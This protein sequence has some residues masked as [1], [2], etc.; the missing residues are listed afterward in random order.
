MRMPL[1]AIYKDDGLPTRK[2]DV[3]GSRQ[4][5]PVKAEPETHCMQR[6]AHG[7]LWLRVAASNSGHV[8]AASVRDVGEVRLRLALA[9]FGWHCPTMDSRDEAVRQDD[10]RSDRRWVLVTDDGAVSTL[11]RATDPTAEE[12]ARVE[13]TLL[14]RATGGWLA[15]QS[16]SFHRGPPPP[17]FVAVRRLAAEGLSFEDAVAAAVARRGM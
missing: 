15:V 7:H 5:A 1:T 17:T 10:G 11:G 3:R 13:E 14:A 6:P 8:P 12:L 9:A 16:H 4:V 2:D